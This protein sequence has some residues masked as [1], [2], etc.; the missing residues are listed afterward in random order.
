MLQCLN[1]NFV[2]TF[3]NKTKFLLAG[4]WLLIFLVSLYLY[5]FQSSFI[6]SKFVS[7]FTSSAIL[8]YAVYLIFSCLRGF[9][10]IPVTYFIF[11]GI[12]L[13]PPWPLYIMA[14]IGVLVSSTCVYYFSEYLNFDEYFE[15]KY[16]SQIDKIKN[17]I[18]KNELPIVVTWSFMPFLPTDVM[19]YVC[20]TLDIDVRKFLFGVMLGEGVSI[21][22]YV[23]L[24][25][26]ILSLISF[27]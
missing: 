7:I 13:I 8:G 25:K 15:T 2:T 4:V 5:F 23:F 9:T 17:V 1:I 27:N 10:L 20:G 22:V 26:E 14:M 11:V 24:G 12:V 6:S 19:C 16:K 21:A 3:R 18:A